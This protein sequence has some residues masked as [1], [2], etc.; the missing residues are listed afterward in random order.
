MNPDNN[1]NPGAQPVTPSPMG[2]GPNPTSAPQTSPTPAPQPNPTVT[3]QANPAPAPQPSPEP[4][5]TQPVITTPATNPNP[6][7][8]NNP[9]LAQPA[10]NMN[11][12]ASTPATAP[13]SNKNLFIIIG[14]IVVV[15]LI[16]VIIAIM[17]LNS[18]NSGN[19]DNKGDQPQTGG[20]S[21]DKNDD[22]KDQ[23]TGDSGNLV[24]PNV[25]GTM[26]VGKVSLTYS[27]NWTEDENNV[28][29][30]KTIYNTAGDT[31]FILTMIE[32][33]R[34]YTLDEYAKAMVDAYTTEGYTTSE[35]LKAEELGDT[36]WQ[37][38]RMRDNETVNDF[39]FYIN[40][41][42]YYTL[43]RATTATF[44]ILTQEDEAVLNSITIK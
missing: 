6:A 19:S 25:G 14:G 20:T 8:T 28:T 12:P 22:N 13:K 16:I 2:A 7:S 32:S 18:N 21:Q 42:E 9:T 38:A 35:E 31:C 33:D 29:D 1:Q 23:A 10:T 24:N 37:H 3:P 15:I 26:T 36:T 40:G 11:N 41:N 34:D 30:T 5:A 44:A 43:T 4:T 27:E 39:W 17:M